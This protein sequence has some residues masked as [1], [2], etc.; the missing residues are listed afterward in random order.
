[1]YVYLGLGS[2]QGDR[3]K[4]LFSSQEMLC[5]AGIE[6]LKRSSVYETE[7]LEVPTAGDFLNL[8]LQARTNL[9]PESLLDTCQVIE[10]ALGRK[11]PSAHRTIDIDILYYGSIVLSK[12]NLEIPH[13]RLYKRQFVLV[14]LQEISPD[15]LD[16]AKKKTIQNLLINCQ[17]R[18]S[19]NRLIGSHP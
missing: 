8:V 7:P 18:S 11:R 19:V 14:P 13:P 3:L 6:I 2:N 10:R 15:F 9:S 5:S 1:M 12:K 16:P 4:Y 17:D